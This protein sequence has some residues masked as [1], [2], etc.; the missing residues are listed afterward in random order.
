MATNGKYD[1]VQKFFTKRNGKMRVC[2]WQNVRFNKTSG[3]TTNLDA[4][5][6]SGFYQTQDGN[7]ESAREFDRLDLWGDGKEWQDYSV[8]T[9]T[10]A[11]HQFNEL[12]FNYT[13]GT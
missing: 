9:P 7:C 3:W 12:P 6:G 11:I 13:R 5:V 4:N 2:S 10:I 1:F 8:G